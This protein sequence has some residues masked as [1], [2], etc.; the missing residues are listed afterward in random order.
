MDITGFIRFFETLPL[1]RIW[2]QIF[3]TK[4]AMGAH[5]RHVWLIAFDFFRL[6][7]TSERIFAFLA[8][9]RL[10]IRSTCPPSSAVTRVRLSVVLCGLS[11]PFT[12]FHNGDIRNLG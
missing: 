12:L 1:L 9:V 10:L 6:P 3:G 4:F 7:V 8:G 5:G 11:Y 2:Y